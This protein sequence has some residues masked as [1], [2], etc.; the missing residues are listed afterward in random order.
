MIMSTSIRGIWIRVSL[1]RYC[2]YPV[3]ISINIYIYIC[4]YGCRPCVSF[5]MFIRVG[6]DLEHPLSTNIH[7]S[8]PPKKASFSMTLENLG[9]Y[10]YF[11]QLVLNGFE[12][13]VDGN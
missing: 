9:K 11:R 7:Q 8:T 1:N 5:I 6:S 10:H 3:R 13:K 12:G 2:I 4:K